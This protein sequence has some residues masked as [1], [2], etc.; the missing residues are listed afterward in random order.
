MQDLGLTKRH[1][2]NNW[3]N[4]KETGNNF[5]VFYDHLSILNDIE[6]IGLNQHNLP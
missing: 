5:L 3:Q 1:R 6:L 2:Y 4:S